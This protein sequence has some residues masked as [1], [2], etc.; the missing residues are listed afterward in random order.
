[1][2][3]IARSRADLDHAAEELRGLGSADAVG[4]VADVRDAGQ[5]DKVFAELGDRWAANSTCSSTRSGRARW[6]ASRISPT[7]S[8]GRL[9]T[10]A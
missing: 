3:V 6:A 7:T 1:M 9:S 2:A 4:L 10:T 5:V 8:G